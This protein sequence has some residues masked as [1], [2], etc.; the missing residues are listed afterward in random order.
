MYDVLSDNLNARVE[1][2]EKHLMKYPLEWTIGYVATRP[3]DMSR[4]YRA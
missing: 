2:L 4:F 1:L 3:I